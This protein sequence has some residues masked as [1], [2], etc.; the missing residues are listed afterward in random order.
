MLE[1]KLDVNSNEFTTKMQ[2]KVKEQSYD[3]EAEDGL[4]NSIHQ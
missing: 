2:Q 1:P 4:M 3:D